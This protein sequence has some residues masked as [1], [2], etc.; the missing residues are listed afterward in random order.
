MLIYGNCNSKKEA[1]METLSRF[2][3]QNRQSFFLFGP[4]GTGKST[5]LL[6]KFPDAIYIDFLDPEQFRI[7]SGKPERI[8]EVIEGNPE[9][10]TIIIDEVQKIPE[11]LSVV[12]QI[13]E[14]RRYIQFI[15]TGSSARKL[16]RAG[17]DLLAG[18]ALLKTCH[19]F[20]ATEL[21]E[22]FSLE[23]SLEIGMLPIVWDAE[24]PNDVLKTYAALYLREE[25]QMERLVRNIGSFSRFLEAI[26]FSHAS[27]LNT[28]EVARE[29]SV[30][31]KTVDNY[32]EILEDLLLSIRLPVF[33]KRAKRKIVSH[34]KFY[35]FDCGVYRSLRPAGP[36]DRPEEIAGHALEGLVLQHLRA[37]NAYS[38][39]NNQIFYWRTKS[40]NEVDFII[41]G[42]DEFAA[43]EVK[44]AA[45]VTNKDLKS[46]LTFKK[47]YPQVKLFLLYRGKE[48]LEING[49]KCIPCDKFLSQLYPNK[50]L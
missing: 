8:S 48:K 34:P 25:V 45:K 12:H 4:R 35:F 47:D 41:Y 22:L 7:Y 37:W 40:G 38:G 16:K 43:I 44:H 33:S 30:E 21:G 13:I 2:I 15:L 39:E 14:K 36:L 1:K 6:N 46:L 32:I 3:H 11:I 50:S 27:V 49:V 9:K 20:M 29:C 24:M 10:K 17:V 5:W 31:R 23:K 28:S 19:P 42:P 18:R 26:S